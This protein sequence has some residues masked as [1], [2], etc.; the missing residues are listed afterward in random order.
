GS[1]GTGRALLCSGSGGRQQRSFDSERAATCIR[2]IEF[3]VV[4]GL[5]QTADYA[6]TVFR[7]YA[8]LLQVPDSDIEAS[9]RVRMQRQQVLYQGKDIEIIVSQHALRHRCCTG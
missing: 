2:N 3:G 1:P 8:E 6:R 5:L 4:P 9:V 7:T